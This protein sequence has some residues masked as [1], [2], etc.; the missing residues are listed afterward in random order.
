MAVVVVIFL[1]IIFS[2]MI[3]YTVA[4][5]DRLS[6]AVRDALFNLGE[7]DEEEELQIIR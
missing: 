2:C 6:K 1:L 3:V 7:S 4:P 5:A